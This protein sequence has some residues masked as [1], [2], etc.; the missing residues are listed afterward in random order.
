MFLDIKTGKAQT[1]YA[2]KFQALLMQFMDGHFVDNVMRKGNCPRRKEKPN[3]KDSW[4]TVR[5]IDYIV[6]RSKSYT[7]DYLHFDIET[8]E[9][10]SIPIR[11]DYGDKN[12]R[13]FLQMLAFYSDAINALGR[14]G[15]PIDYYLQTGEV[16]NVFPKEIHTHH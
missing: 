15:G 2:H 10:T 16:P 5:T 6:P 3:D 4:Y 14:P 7:L 1:D 8:G 13:R 12:G 11:I 9:L